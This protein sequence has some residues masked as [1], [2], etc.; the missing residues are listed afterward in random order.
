LEEF[1]HESAQLAALPADAREAL[2]KASD[3]FT[4]GRG[5][6]LFRQGMMADA[7]YIVASGTLA[8]ATRIPGDSLAAVSR[9]EAGEVVG[10]FALLDDGPRSANVTAI[11]DSA[12]LRL[13]RTRFLALLADGKPW[14]IELIDALRCLVAQRT[15]ATLARI[16]AAERYDLTSLRMPATDRQLDTFSDPVPLF[17]ALG[18]LAAL[19]PAGTAMLATAG[20]CIVVPRGTRLTETGAAPEALTLVLRGA[21]RAVLPRAEGCEQIMVHGPGEITGLIGLCDGAPQP[22]GLEAAE[23]SVVLQLPAALFETLRRGAD[24]HALALFGVAGRQLVRDQRRANRHLGRAVSLAQFN[25]H[26]GRSAA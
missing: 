6:T 12:G 17:A 3:H 16:A 5:E 4:V 19:E 21:L 25:N 7:L 22:L 23:D 14:T 9:I 10:E 18:R 15:R 26:P 24:R 2:A 20:T 11:V 1:L 8:I 13:P